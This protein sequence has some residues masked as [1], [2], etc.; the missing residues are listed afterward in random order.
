MIVA[1]RTEVLI[2]PEL[3]QPLLPPR[4]ERV[5]VVVITQPAATT[6]AVEVASRLRSEGLAAEV[7]GL[8]DREEAK[9]LEVVADLYH[10]LSDLGLTVHD[11]VMGVGGGSVTD[12]AGFV[13]GTWLRGVEAVHLPTTFL[14]AIDAAIGG[15][16]GIN[17]G[18]KNLVGIFWHPSRVIV[19]TTVLAALPPYLIREGMAEAYKSGLVGDAAL[20]TM[21]EGDGLDSPIDEVVTRALSVKA[22]LVAR[23]PLD[24]AERAFLNFG[25]TVGHAIEY[26]S[27]LSHGES[28]SLGMLAAAKVSEKRFGFEEG[29][30]L[31]NCLAG[32]GL[33]VTVDGLDRTRVIDLVGR[34]KKRD[35]SGVRMVLLKSVAN[36]VLERVDRGDIEL[37]LD[38][39]GVRGG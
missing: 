21:I 17:L 31:E 4:E 34:D 37:A 33:P 24:R 3:P 32:L 10:S 9:T 25:H 27:T 11:T 14:G 13:A 8:P 6:K 38:A 5:S 29:Q 20:A 23:D 2:G 12:V 36:P 1:G 19:D 22:A 39:I 16:T 26:A 30:R 35:S 15:K 28:V 7:I 18:G